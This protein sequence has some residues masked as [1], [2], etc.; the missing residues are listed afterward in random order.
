MANAQERVAVSPCIEAKLAKIRELLT[1][2]D[3]DIPLLPNLGSPPA[4]PYSAAEWDAAVTAGLHEHFP[5]PER[6]V[7]PLIALETGVLSEGQLKEREHW[8]RL[9][10]LTGYARRL[11][12]VTREDL[13]QTTVLA[14]R[15]NLDLTS[16]S[17][18]LVANARQAGIKPLERDPDGKP[19]TSIE[20]FRKVGCRPWP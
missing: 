17:E 1:T 3:G 9:S 15:M 14:R 13:L 2:G 20:Q 5:M 4:R 18:Q 7:L 16:I 10:A 12:S 8:L 6:A 11:N 19:T